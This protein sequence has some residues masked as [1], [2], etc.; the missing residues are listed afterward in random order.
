MGACAPGVTAER[1]NRSEATVPRGTNRVLLTHMSKG[2]S[3]KDVRAKVGVNAIPV[4]GGQPSGATML[5]SMHVG[6]TLRMLSAS[7]TG[8]YSVSRH[9]AGSAGRVGRHGKATSSGGITMVNP[10]REA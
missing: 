7:Q 1:D 4:H 9:V 3:G 2:G 6:S 10:L 5:K 8:R